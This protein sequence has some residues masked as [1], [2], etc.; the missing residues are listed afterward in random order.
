MKKSAIREYRIWKAMKARCK[1]P[2]VRKGVY[3]SIEVC[4]RWR[5]SYNAFI[6]DMGP[7][8][9]TEHSIDRI[10][11]TKGY[12][13]E[14]CRWA[15][16]KEQSS[17]R[18]D[19]NI[20]IEYN[21]EK[22]TLKDWSCIFGIKYTTLYNRI[23]RKGLTFEESLKY[24]KLFNY[25]GETGLLKDLCFKYSIVSYTL[26]VDRL[27]RGWSLEKAMTTPKIIK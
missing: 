6:E 12:Y 1:A 13:K 15:T 27:H 4:E 26:V 23:F 17:N 11:N 24:S 16:A 5:N 25:N 22:H 2:S 3:L 7:A 19:F 10:D 21:N 14:N 20:I 8:P 18:G 9:T